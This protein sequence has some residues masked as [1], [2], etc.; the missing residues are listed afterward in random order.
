MLSSLVNNS[1]QNP[2]EW[3]AALQ[4]LFANPIALQRFMQALHSQQFSPGAGLPNAEHDASV[5]PRLATHQLTPYDPN[6]YDFSRLHTDLPPS[7]IAASAADRA[8]A[9]EMA[10][11]LLGSLIP[12]EDAPAL[13]P[14]VESANRLQKTYH[15]ASEIDADVDA[16][17]YS[18]NSLISGMGIDPNQVSATPHE[19]RAATPTQL[20]DG[21]GTDASDFDFES[22]LNDIATRHP[23][24]NGYVDVTRGFD[25]MARLDGTAVGDAATDQ[26]GAFLDDTSDTASMH[27]DTLEYPPV[28]LAGTK[29]KSDVAELPP[30]IVSHDSPAAVPKVKR[31]R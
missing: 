31:K 24:E 3:N 20:P 2:G 26:L 23:T 13:E 14:L 7:T 28:P 1:T 4:S 12:K 10:P 30:P 22:F 16:L 15:D 11:G 8:H 6:A 18:L 17:Q 25:P 29:R 21:G 5:D 19:E 27:N 9:S